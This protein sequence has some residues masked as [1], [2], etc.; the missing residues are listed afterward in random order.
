MTKLKMIALAIFAIFTISS[1]SAEYAIDANAIKLKWTGEKFGGEHYGMIQSKGGYLN[2]EGGKITGGKVVIDME[3]M[4][5][6]DLEPGEWHDKLIGHLKSDDFFGVDK[7][8]TAN[9]EIFAVKDKGNGDIKVTGK[10]TLKGI[11]KQ[12]TFDAKYKMDGNKIM[13]EGRMVV[14]RTKYDIKYGSGSFFDVAQ[15]KLIYDEFFIDINLT[16]QK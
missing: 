6:D 1:F 16:A 9:F 2:V 3:S 13:A 7:F 15:D 12:V 4:T 8:K 14:D 10:L 5:C 11:T